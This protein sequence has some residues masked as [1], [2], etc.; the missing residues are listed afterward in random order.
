MKTIAIIGAKGT[1]GK[2]L[3]EFFK[4]LN[5]QVLS[6]DLDTDLTLEV[7]A[8]KADVVFIVTLPIEEVGELI[9]QAISVMRPGTLLIHGTSVENPVTNKINSGEVCSKKINFC[10]WH[11]Q[12]RPEVPLANTLFGQHITVSGCGDDWEMWRKW[13]YKQFQPSQPFIHGLAI[14]EHDQITSVS[15]LFHMLTALII[16]KIWSNLPKSRV[17][18][19]IRICGPPGRL[20]IRSGLRVGTGA[21]VAESVVYNHPYTLT[22]IDWFLETGKSLRLAVQERKPGVLTSWFNNG[23]L[24][25]EPTDLARWDSNTAR[26]SRFDSDMEEA[27][28]EFRFSRE[29]NKI[30]LL[31]KILEQFDVRDIDKTS[32]LAQKNPDGGCTIIIGIY[33]ISEAALEAERVIRS[34]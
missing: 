3:V 9:H 4:N 17:N 12:F 27:R 15:Q 31:A 23:R 5:H 1:V 33:E 8:A 19:A 26:L 21:K 20:L 18:M 32:T 7:A 10:H 2:T 6:V 34:W 24:I 29:K 13:L 14:G 16:S 11:F 25:L 22:V 28:L 30:G